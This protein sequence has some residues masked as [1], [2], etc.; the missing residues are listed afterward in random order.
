MAT[1][2]G[3]LNQLDLRGVTDF[4]GLLPR[5]SVDDDGPVEAVRGIL[6]EVESRGDE[7]VRE[8]TSRFDGVDL[9][10]LR[11][12][13]EEIQ[14]ALDS[15]APELRTALELARDRIADH[16]RSQLHAAVDHGS[17]GVHIRSYRT[18][19]GRAGCYVPGG[20]AAYPSTLLMT[21]V[22]A[23][24]AGVGEVVVCVPADK[25]TG[26]VAAVTLAAAA[27]AG[28]AEVYAIGG[29]Q[30]IAAMAYGTESIAAVDVICGPGNKYVAIAKQQVAAR[31]GVAAAFAGPSEVVVIADGSVPATF[32][33]IDVILQA[34]HGP[35]GL[36]WLITWDQSVAES[37][38]SE[39]GRITENS[40]RRAEITATLAEGGYAVLVDSPE[41]ALQ[42]SNLVAPEHLELLCHEAE[43][44][45]P[46]IEN[47][48]AVFVGP[49]SPASVGDYVAGPSH[50]LPTFGTARF[51]SAL[52]VDDFLKQ[53]HIITV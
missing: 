29:A 48:G 11:V 34:E 1:L 22:P 25:A 30:A 38:T 18:P 49:W 13:A 32:A 4:A 53:H 6:A 46:L 2:I 37:V 14:L 23:L 17:D 44:L 40:P 52:T 51:A 20:R 16:H 27:L 50:V 33:A 43:S 3:V 35:D 39:V 28:V 12:S 36:A 24:V 26:K 47:A 42:V 31:V 8:F 19:V 9:G 21:A 7:A 10:D 45:L 5:P 41:A 15:L